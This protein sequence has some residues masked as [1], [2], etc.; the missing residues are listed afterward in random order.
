VTNLR[1][2][3]RAANTSEQLRA[4]LGAGAEGLPPVP[5]ALLGEQK[6]KLI[7]SINLRL[8][9]LRTRLNNER[10]QRLAALS[11]STLKGILG[12]GVIAFGLRRTK[13]MVVQK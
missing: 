10:Q 9:Q 11:V 3:I 1:D 12:A 7:E 8:S 6:T 4:A 5:S 2:R 13:Q